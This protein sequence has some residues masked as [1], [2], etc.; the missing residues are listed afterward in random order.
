[1]DQLRVTLFTFFRCSEVL[2]M[3][4]NINKHAAYMGSTVGY[5]T[6]QVKAHPEILRKGQ[7]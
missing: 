3:I 4:A 7:V 1:M 5:I 6:D 2:S